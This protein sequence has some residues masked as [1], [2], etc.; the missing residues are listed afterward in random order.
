MGLNGTLKVFFYIIII[1]LRPKSYCALWRMKRCNFVWT[2]GIHLIVISANLIQTK[3]SRHWPICTVTLILVFRLLFFGKAQGKD[4]YCKQMLVISSTADHEETFGPQALPPCSI[5][6]NPKGLKSTQ[7]FISTTYTL[8][9]CWLCDSN[10]T[11]R[12][13]RQWIELKN[14]NP[15]VITFC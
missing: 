12:I 7:L 9:Y 10:N 4:S 3:E 2:N 13:S 14:G 11:R 1:I 15:F 5:W 8:I 6:S